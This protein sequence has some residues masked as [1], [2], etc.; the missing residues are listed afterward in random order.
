M[1]LRI[2]K[3]VVFLLPIFLLTFLVSTELAL[4]LPYGI[5]TYG[6]GQYGGDTVLPVVEI[7]SPVFGFVTVSNTVSYITAFQ[8]K[9]NVIIC[10]LINS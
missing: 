4:A 6:I 7:L 9:Y 1:K 5:D 2:K 8:R 3:N 10:S